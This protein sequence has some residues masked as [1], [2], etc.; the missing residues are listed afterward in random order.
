[1]STDQRLPSS[2]PLEGYHLERQKQQQLERLVA[3]GLLD[4]E[5]RSNVKK[6]RNVG[7][8]EPGTLY[9]QFATFLPSCPLFVRD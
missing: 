3:V 8:K 5:P 7:F 9:P 1:M 2:L 6:K 4:P